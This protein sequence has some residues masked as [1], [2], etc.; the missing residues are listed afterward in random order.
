MKNL[1]YTKYRWFI[2]L[3]LFIVGTAQGITLISPSPLVGEISKT[4]GV[5]LGQVT[6][7][8]MG[9]FTFCVAISA[10]LGGSLIDKFGSVRIWVVCSC[11]MG[12]GLNLN[13]NSWRYH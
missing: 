4:L 3:V 7:I 11:M 1:T 13:T 5:S 9:S 8:T 2:L 12:I 10:I 6:A